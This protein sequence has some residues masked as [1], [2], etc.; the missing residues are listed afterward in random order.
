MLIVSLT[1]CNWKWFPLRWQSQTQLVD[2]FVSATSIDQIIGQ[3]R[4]RF[5][6]LKTTKSL[7]IDSNYTNDTAIPVCKFQWYSKDIPPGGLNVL[8]INANFNSV[9]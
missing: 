7:K 1:Y 8:F 2:V 6:V 5:P 4:I 9:K 3:K